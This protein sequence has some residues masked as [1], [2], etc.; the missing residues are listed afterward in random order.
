MLHKQKGHALMIASVCKTDLMKAV[1]VK[2]SE[3]QVLS[4]DYLSP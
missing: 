4:K 2:Q 1:L 3:V